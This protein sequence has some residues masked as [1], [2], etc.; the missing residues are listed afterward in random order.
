MIISKSR[1][2]LITGGSRGIGLSIKK[3]FEANGID[4]IAPSR[5]ELNLGDPVS[6][7]KFISDNCFF[8]DI[9]VNCAG[10][11]II[12]PLEMLEMSEMHRVFQVNFF[13]AVQLLKGLLP[14]MRERHYGRIV[15]IESLYAIISREGRLS[16]AASKSSLS[17][18]TKTLAIEYGKD[19]VLVN[20]VLPGYV[21]T[22]MTKNNLSNDEIDE[23]CKRIPLKRLAEPE[24]IAK[25]VYFLCSDNNTYITGQLIVIDG[26]FSI[27]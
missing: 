23:I 25:L 20:A 5:N 22:E 4:V 16:Y 26:G 19:N 9:I 7:N 3:T 18:L 10:I 21:M 24:E 17:A 6:I 27:N 1:N 11:N 8:F 12:S 2:A 13:G 14:S 15:N